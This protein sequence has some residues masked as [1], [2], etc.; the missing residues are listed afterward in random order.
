M[1]EV[2]RAHT[3][4]HSVCLHAWAE[5]NYSVSDMQS[6]ILALATAETSVSQQQKDFF[7]K[8]LYIL[9]SLEAFFQLYERCRNSVLISMYGDNAQKEIEILDR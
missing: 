2:E 4:L 8:K 5:D 6:Q 9:I 3:I 7:R 1:S